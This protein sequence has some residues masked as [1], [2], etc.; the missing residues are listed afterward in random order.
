MSF[1][2][3]QYVHAADT[4]V[5]TVGSDTPGGNLAQVTGAEVSVTVS[6]TSQCLLVLSGSVQTQTAESY[7]GY[8]VNSDTPVVLLSTSRSDSVINFVHHCGFVHP[9]TLPAGTHTVKLMAARA[10]NNTIILGAGG[11]NKIRLSVV[12][13]GRPS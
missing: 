6:Q 11:I 1:S 12:V 3:N 2:I 5:S 13:L 7:I 10:V 8:Q 9:F 4:T